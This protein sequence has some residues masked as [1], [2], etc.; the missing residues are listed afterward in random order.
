MSED[1]LRSWISSQEF[2]EA[3]TLIWR[4]VQREAFPE[5]YRLLKT[6]E[7][8]SNMAVVNKSSSL[9]KLSPFLDPSGVIRMGDRIGATPLV[10]YE[11]KY[12]IILP[13]KNMQ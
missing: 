10:P 11:A 3:E 5:E 8:R 2:A 9:Y 12:P 13:K 7:N 6:S 1:D 4:Q